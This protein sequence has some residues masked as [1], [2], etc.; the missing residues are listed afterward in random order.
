MEQ[1]KLYSPLSR[2]DFATHRDGW[3]SALLLQPDLLERPDITQIRCPYGQRTDARAVFQGWLRE[4]AVAVALREMDVFSQCYAPKF[5]VDGWNSGRLKWNSYDVR[6]DDS[7]FEVKPKCMWGN[8]YRL[9]KAQ[10]LSINHTYLTVVADD[11][12]MRFIRWGDVARGHV[13]RFDGTDWVYFTPNQ[14]KLYGM[15]ATQFSEYV[16]G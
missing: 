16:L 3:L 2:Y 6:A 8:N 11:G 7:Y 10:K 5:K 9:V 15:T 4:A 14:M 12:D 1:I 13:E